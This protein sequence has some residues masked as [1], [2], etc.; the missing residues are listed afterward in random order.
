MNIK[1]NLEKV[2]VCFALKQYGENDDEKY[3]QLPVDK[4]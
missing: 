4:L 3:G 1:I 2:P